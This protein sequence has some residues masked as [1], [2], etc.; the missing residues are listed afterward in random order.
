MDAFRQ[1]DAVA[2]PLG[3]VNVDTDQISPALYLQK[4]RSAP[5]GSFLFHDVRH[6]AQGARRP[7]FLLNQAVYADARILVAGRNFGCGS[8]REH[9]VWALCD[10]GFRAVIAP[11]FGDI[12]FNN[13]LKNGLLPVRLPEDRVDALLAALRAQPGAQ[14]QIDLAAQTVRGPAGFAAEFSIEPFARHCLLEGL[15][16]LDYTLSQRAHIE[17]FERGLGTAA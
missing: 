3:N 1:L 9:A 16:E 8:S 13:S 11:S 12:F 17:A 2:A 15:D 10:G 5:F 7:E 14:V 4:P 6:D